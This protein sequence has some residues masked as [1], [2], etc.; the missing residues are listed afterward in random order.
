MPIVK[1]FEYIPNFKINLAVECPTFC[2]RT[3]VSYI[4]IEKLQNVI[5]II[6]LTLNL[7][8]AVTSLRNIDS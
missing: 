5:F 1:S 2:S 4:I 8:V 6:Y 3:F 7:S